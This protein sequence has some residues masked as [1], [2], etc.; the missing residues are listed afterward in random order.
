MSPSHSWV[1]SLPLFSP[2]F[3]EYDDQKY[4][5]RAIHA[6]VHKLPEKNRAMLD[7]LTNHLLKYVHINTYCALIVQCLEKGPYS[8]FAKN[9]FKNA[10]TRDIFSW[11][12]QIVFQLRGICGEIFLFTIFCQTITQERQPH[13]IKPFLASSHHYRCVTVD[14]SAR[15]ATFETL[16]A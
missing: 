10:L 9:V 3:T 1:I 4:R 15:K 16:M 12:M 11:F 5:E 6:L 13:T 7:L 14:L 8:Y 2:C